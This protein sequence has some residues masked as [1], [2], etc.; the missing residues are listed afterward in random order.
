MAAAGLEL[1]VVLRGTSLDGRGG[2]VRLHASVLSALG[3]APWDPV[4]VAGRRVTG[5]LVAQSPHDADPRVMYADEIVLGN[6]DVVSQSQVRVERT[7]LQPCG[8]LIVSGAPEISTVV[9]PETVRLALMGKIVTQGD[10]LSLLPQDFALPVGAT[11]A[12]LD[13]A[14]HSLQLSLGPAWTQALVRVV[15]GPAE[16]A[17]VGPSTIVGWA[18]GATTTGSPAYVVPSLHTSMHGPMQ[19]AAPDGPP[20]WAGD[21]LAG[22]PPPDPST[23]TPLPPPP[24]PFPTS[25]PRRGPLPMPAGIHVPP[26]PTMMPPPIAAV[27]EEILPGLEHQAASLREWLD[28][29]FHHADLLGKLGTKPSM[30]VLLSG[31]AGSGKV[32]LVRQVATSLGA[33]NVQLWGPAVA[34]LDATAA[35]KR[36][37]DA[38]ASAEHCAPSVLL[39]EDVETLIPRDTGPDG[40]NAPIASLVLEQIENTITAGRVAVV[41]TT[42]APEAVAGELR[43]PGMLDHELSIALPDRG[44]R[45]RLLDLLC[46]PLALA[47]DVTL[48]DIAAR[49]PGFVVADLTA[50]GRDAAQRAAVRERE[51]PTGAP[52]VCAADFD[53]ALSA[54]RPT[55]MSEGALDVGRLTLDDV[56]DM[57]DVKEAL[58]ETVLWPLR[59]PDTFTR[60]GIAAPH[61]VLLYGPPGCGKTYLVRALAGTGEAN[62]LSVKGAELL[63][64]WVGESESGVRE[65]FRRARDAAPSLVFLD[66]IDALAPVRGQ[67]T[68]SGVTDRVVA[69]LLTELDGVEALRNIVVVGATNRPDLV[70]PALLRPGRLER[71]VYVPPPDAAARA[72]IL[73][74]AGKHTPFAPE[75][76][77]NELGAACDGFSAADCAA[78]VREAALAAM[79]RSMDAPAVTAADVAEART[80]VRPSLDAAQVAE[81]ADYAKRHPTG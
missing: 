25:A 45:R 57:K 65:L 23:R 17:L 7:P 76:D 54:V 74:V 78:L 71:I 29:G 44:T 51:H 56:G 26:P 16:P 49:T 20:P 11:S 12:L 40:R 41:C 1:T 3:V 38:A 73:A 67:S 33:Q 31:P 32:Q 36:L 8:Q 39:I 62:V 21:P 58:T 13:Q 81:L 9:D 66:E 4:R 61:G 34:A 19:V 2:V 63:S 6:L 52:E 68:D 75:V 59:Y 27:P 79:R 5:A 69:A 18:G 50:L 30:G 80:R 28:L 64:K 22:P 60:L 24:Q 35:A 70:D 42:S 10:A 47:H 55:A 43:Y 53:A 37:Q 72:E 15:E 46:R 14:R 48:D 77:L